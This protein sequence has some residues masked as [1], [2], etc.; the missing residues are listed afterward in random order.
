MSYDYLSDRLTDVVR[1]N[2]DSTALVQGALA[3]SFGEL[4][5]RIDKVTSYLLGHGVKTGDRIALLMDRGI[6]CCIALL[7]IRRAG[8]VAV[9]MDLNL[10]RQRINY[11]LQDSEPCFVFGEVDESFSHI[12]NPENTI[13]AQGMQSVY[14]QAR[15]TETRTIDSSAVDAYVIYTSGTT[16]VPKGILQTRETLNNLIRWQNEESGIFSSGKVLQ[17]SSIAFDVCLQEIFGTL[18][19]GGVLH[20]LPEDAKYDQTEMISYI[21]EHGINVVYLSVSSLTGILSTTDDLLRAAT[22]LTDIV[23]A[24]EQLYITPVLKRLLNETA[25]RLH[26]HYGVSES[27]VVTSLTLQGGSAA[28]ISRVPVGFPISNIEIRLLRPDGTDITEPGEQGELFL[29]GPCLARGYINKPEAQAERFVTLAGNPFFKTGDLAKYDAQG[30]LVF[31]NRTD[32][33]VKI[34]GHLV[35]LGEVES[36]LRALPQ[37]TGA[38]VLAVPN[39]RGQNILAAWYTAPEDQDSVQLRRALALTLPGYMIPT[40]IVWLRAFPIG[41]TGKIDK[42]ALVPSTGTEPGDAAAVTDDLLSFTSLV[43]QVLELEQ[44]EPACS[45]FDAGANSI[46]LIQGAAKLTTALGISLPPKV[47]FQHGSAQKLFDFVRNERSPFQAPPAPQPI[48]PV[49]ADKDDTD[50]IAIVGASGYFPDADDVFELWDMLIEGRSGLRTMPTDTTPG[51][52]F[53]GSRPD[54]AQIIGKRG[55]IANSLHFDAGF[56]GISAKEAQ[57]MDP[58]HR[59]LLQA[60][61]DALE[62]SGYDLGKK[63]ALDVGVYV[64][65]EFPSYILELVEHVETTADFLQALIGNDKDFIASRVAYKLNLT[66]P[67]LG[68]QT[69]CST[70]LVAVHLAS[71]AIRNGECEAAIAGAASMQYPQEACPTFEP[72]LILSSDGETRPFDTAAQGT[73]ITSGVGVV[74]LK[75]LSAALRDNN[76]ILAI[77]KSTAINNDGADKVGYTAPSVSGQTRVIRKA[78]QNAAL[79]PGQIDFIEAHGTATPLGDAI[80]IQGLRDV[81]IS[82][83]PVPASPL[84]L[85]SVKGNIGHTNRAAGVCGLI[86]SAMALHTGMWPKT[87]NHQQP[88]PDLG[89]DASRLKVATANVPIVTGSKPTFIGVSSYGFGGTNAHCI[90][91]GFEP[92]LRTADN[93]DEPQLI[94]V[95]GKTPLSLDTHCAKLAHWMHTLDA[96]LVEAAAILNQPGKYQDTVKAF[97]ASSLPQLVTGLDESPSHL[98]P[99]QTSAGKKLA[100]LFPGHGR[101][102]ITAGPGLYHRYPRFR[103]HVDQAMGY[104]RPDNRDVLQRWLTDPEELSPVICDRAELLQPLILM[105]SYSTAHLLEDFGLRPDVLIGHSLGEYSAACFAQA[106]SL[107]DGVKLVQERGRLEDLHAVNGAMVSVSLSQA[108]VMESLTRCAAA[109]LYHSGTNSREHTLVSGSQEAITDFTRQLADDAIRFTLLPNKKA[110]HCPLMTQAAQPLDGLANM[111]AWHEPKL[112]IY[113]SLNGKRLTKEQMSNGMHWTAHSIEPVQFGQ[114]LEESQKQMGDLMYI[115]AGP[116]SGLPTLAKYQFPDSDTQGLATYPRAG[117]EGDVAT[118]LRA[119]G[120]ACRWGMALDLTV[121]N[122]TQ[123]PHRRHFLPSHPFVGT[124]YQVTNNRKRSAPARPLKGTTAPQLWNYQAAW[125]ATF[126]NDLPTILENFNPIVFQ[127]LSDLE[128]AASSPAALLAYLCDAS[129]GNVHLD[130]VLID[131]NQGDDHPDKAAIPQSFITLLSALQRTPRPPRSLTVFS[132]S[133]SQPSPESVTA[134]S[135]LIRV[136]SQEKQQ[137]RYAVIHGK[138]FDTRIVCNE[139]LARNFEPVAHYD[140]VRYRLDYRLAP[141]PSAK[142]DELLGATVCLI[143][144]GCGRVGKEVARYLAS[145]NVTPVIMGRSPATAPKVTQLL[146]ELSALCPERVYLSC[147]VADAGSFQRAIKQLDARGINIDAVFHA[148]AELDEGSFLEFIGSEDEQ[149][150]ASQRS[151]KALGLLVIESTFADRPMKFKLACSS[152]SVMLGGLGYGP[153]VW[154]NIMLEDT[155]RQVSRTSR[156][157]WNII[158]WD[159][160]DIIL[161]KT[162]TNIQL[163]STH[164]FPKMDLA[165]ALQVIPAALASNECIFTLSTVDLNER[166]AS[167]QE[168]LALS[169]ESERLE[170]EHGHPAIQQPLTLRSQLSRIWTKVLGVDIDDEASFLKL[171]GDSL[172]A[173]KVVL[174]V[175][176]ALGVKLSPKDML[177]TKTFSEF[178][179]RVTTLSPQANDIAPVDLKWIMEPP[180]I[181]DASQIQERWYKLE[182]QGYGY[183]SV[184][185]AIE[186]PI[187]LTIARTAYE[188]LCTRHDVLRSCY[189]SKPGGAIRQRLAEHIPHLQVLDFTDSGTACERAR[190]QDLLEREFD[191]GVEAPLEFALVRQSES[192]HFLAGRIHHIAI[193]GWSFSLFVERFEQYYRALEAGQDDIPAVKQ[194][195]NFSAYQNKQARSGGYEKNRYFWR[196]HFRG[197]TTITTLPSDPA[198]EPINERSATAA[199]LS[200]VLSADKLALLK[201]AARRSQTTL[202]PLFTAAFVMMLKEVTHTHDLI[203]GTTAAGRHHAGLDEVIGCFVNPLPLRFNLTG[204]DRTELILQRVN[205]ILLDFHQHQDYSL[206]DLV[207]SVEP[208]VGCSLND[209]FKAYILL[210]NFP[211]DS[212]RGHRTYSSGRPEALGLAKFPAEKLMRDFE[213]VIQTEGDHYLMEFSYRADKFTQSQIEQWVERYFNLLD[214]IVEEA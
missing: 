30:R 86:K 76:P 192:R 113:S 98:C 183:I 57:W 95:K 167:T 83:Q 135:S 39:S 198:L 21:V 88:N 50:E 132:E 6:D 166:L 4:A 143:T 140:Q 146:S 11:I 2:P 5:K 61:Y 180:Q 19:S 20:I 155:A 90:L 122:G 62:S 163:G 139:L 44:L 177:E 141:L 97:V 24:G 43:Q 49:T 138:K 78:L 196:E 189:V 112:P 119:L 94:V 12:V 37:I 54:Q 214:L 87:I 133:D 205:E 123:K 9:L 213:L 115:E 38:V 126:P 52:W 125:R 59:L 142:P 182:P 66:G 85:G 48:T 103:K 204:L 68:V 178:V 22:S 121:I 63:A 14:N 105:L 151:A 26:N 209:A 16:G 211:K 81:F 201:D 187:N 186:G 116:T 144:G 25:V 70:S 147:D 51:P 67:A 10:P 172:G 188:W 193:D 153:Y 159:V 207:Q 145:H 69:A 120:D 3:L 206:I 8:G 150:Y 129:T 162:G 108:Q 60:S 156:C 203:I 175:N 124:A 152:N 74:V 176:K 32:D 181:A 117:S 185:I 170:P 184:L 55:I 18:T 130:V 46:S 102:E 31:I 64:G 136:L 164:L 202:F 197:A 13:S 41:P 77:L 29:A 73:N 27:H 148:A 137:T 114:A 58:Q 134:F 210:Q 171:G 35:E 101:N 100:F 1:S 84:I 118:L 71:Q 131:K 82:H 34:S 40:K 169:S 107:E 195:A 33:Q 72:G 190:L 7:A 47:L 111:C 194:Y 165:G 106:L 99:A 208:F 75:R 128:H 89:L 17:V 110:N 191:L 80:E 127:S 200:T 174:E 65:S 109:P 154:S 157:A 161:D 149:Q 179:N 158:R 23:T 168:A 36:V 96:G 104:L 92:A 160:W 212:V 28:Q 79:E 199:S 56:F 45:F 53:D 15:S 42:K 93:R 173:I 91:Q